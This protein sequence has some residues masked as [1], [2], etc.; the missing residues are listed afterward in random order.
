MTTR[1]LMLSKPE[2][3]YMKRYFVSALIVLLS[4]LLAFPQQDAVLQ[5]LKD[6][7]HGS[8]KMEQA[9]RLMSIYHQAQLTDELIKFNASVPAD[10][11]QQQVWY[12]TG[13]FF[14]DQA[15][16]KQA[17]S[18]GEKALPLCHDDEM[19]ANC[20]NLLSLACFRMGNYEKAAH[21]A[22]ECYKLDEKQ[23]D[24]DLM[25]SSLNTIAGIYLGANQPQEAEKYILKAIDM[26]GKANNLARQA[27]LHGTASEVYHAMLNDDKALDHINTACRLE[28]QL[29][30]EDKLMVRL[31]QKASVLN[32]LQR[33]QEAEQVLKPV[34]PALRRLGDIHSL[35]IACNKMGMALFSQKREQEAV[36]YFREAAGIFVKTGDLGNELHARRG[37]Y[38]SLW[39]SNP[40]SAKLEL[41]RFDF[42]KDSLYSH[43]S[44]QSLA[45]FN[46]ELENDW[47]KQENA[48]QRSRTTYIIIGAVLMAILIAAC[49]WWWMRRRARMREEAL[50]AIID[51]LTKTPHDTIAAPESQDEFSQNDRDFLS[52]IVSFV[53]DNMQNGVTVESLADKMCITR[54][55]LNR[56]VKNITGTTTQQYITRIRLEHARLLLQQDASLP[57]TEVAMQCGFDDASS[58]TRV[59]KRT[60]GATPSQ[61][62]GTKN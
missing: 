7:D 22:L 48:A 5:A 9:N 12:W 2:L 35:G 37:L 46:A 60:F 52:Q 25:S 55:H 14:Y 40:D 54:G 20:L 30:R 58:F 24:P 57:I 32:G 16:Y 44:A 53:K 18:Y 38:E 56:R 3:K 23:G 50:Q 42:L 39:H 13:E 45:R 47:L 6:F 10:S 17:I 41:D 62:R 59:F 27:V 8:Q 29:G 36:N 19:K 1:T 4:A 11:M 51:E 61:H 15:Q 33:Y 34:I 28:Q 31:T 43:A 21:Y 26:A 49:V